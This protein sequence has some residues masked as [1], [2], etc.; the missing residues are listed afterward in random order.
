MTIH[1]P[2]SLWLCHYTL[3]LCTLVG[4]ALCCSSLIDRQIRMM[5]WY[6]HNIINKNRTLTGQSAVKSV[7]FNGRTLTICSTVPW[8]KGHNFCEFARSGEGQPQTDRIRL[9]LLLDSWIQSPLFPAQCVQEGSD[10]RSQN[11]INSKLISQSSLSAVTQPNF[12]K[13]LSSEQ[14]PI[15]RPAPRPPAPLTRR[16]IQKQKFHCVPDLEDPSYY[17]NVLLIKNKK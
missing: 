12:S 16:F 7:F 17:W 13:L 5:E 4:V 1:P 10:L 9:S 3:D 15:S 6:K 8:I 14:H 2:L 11:M